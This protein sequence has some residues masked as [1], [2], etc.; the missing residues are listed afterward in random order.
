MTSSNGA[1]RRAVI[2]RKMLDVA[3]DDMPPGLD[4]HV[5]IM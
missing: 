3:V 2:Q 5:P 4:Y 1:M